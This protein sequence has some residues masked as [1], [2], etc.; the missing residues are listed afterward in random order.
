MMSVHRLFFTGFPIHHSFIVTSYPP[1]LVFLYS[2]EN[3]LSSDTGDICLVKTTR[4]FP[5]VNFVR[6]TVLKDVND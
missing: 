5:K 1:T 2:D 3:K 6:V 4:G